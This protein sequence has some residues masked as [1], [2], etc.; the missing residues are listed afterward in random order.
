MKAYLLIAIIACATA[1]A[2]FQ[3]NMEYNM[4]KFKDLV[5]G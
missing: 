3:N 5:E 2:G 4:K 1:S